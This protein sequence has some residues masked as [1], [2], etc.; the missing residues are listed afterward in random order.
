M[1]PQVKRSSDEERLGIEETP[2]IEWLVRHLL[3]TGLE[4]SL[5]DDAALFPCPC[6]TVRILLTCQS[7]ELV[8]GNLPCAVD[9]SWS[10][11]TPWSSCSRSCDVGSRRRFR[12]P[13]NPPAAL[14]GRECEGDMVE[15]EYCSLQLCDRVWSEWGHWSEC[16]VSCGG[17]FRN[18]TRV[19]ISSQSSQ[20][21]SCNTHP[22]EAHPSNCSE[23]T[24][25]RDCS[26]GADTCTEL[27][28][29]EE[30]SWNCS[31]G[32]YCQDGLLLQELVPGENGLCGVI[33]HEA[34]GMV[35]DLEAG[36]VTAPLP[37]EMGISARV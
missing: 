5:A 14:G 24:V 23:G 19:N 13:T 6:D 33:A 21:T 16:S 29:G 10:R 4:E 7:G 36:F 12:S 3:V 32:C 27:S 18:R 35:C 34:V 28:V 30:L 9:C 8:C 17:G 25:W 22:C 37:R 31:S 26:I 11:W 15:T 1:L 2:L 20:L